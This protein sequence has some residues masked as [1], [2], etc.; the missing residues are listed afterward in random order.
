MSAAHTPESVRLAALRLGQARYAPYF[1]RYALGRRVAGGWAV[2]LSHVLPTGRSL[3]LGELRLDDSGALLEG[4]E[5][6]AIQAELQ[7]AY[8][9][10][11]TFPPEHTARVVGQARAMLGA[12]TAAVERATLW[13]AIEP[14]DEACELLVPFAPHSPE[15]AA[16][17]ASLGAQID[18]LQALQAAV[19]A[20]D[21]AADDPAQRAAVGQIAALDDGGAPLVRR[22]R[23]R[24]LREGAALFLEGEVL[25]SAERPTLEI[26]LQGLVTI[27][28]ADARSDAP[29]ALIQALTR[30]ALEGAVARGVVE[31][32]GAS[33]P[34]VLQ[35][36]D[37]S[38]G[39]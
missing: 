4:P 26:A 7:R 11:A 37:Q 25:E 15:A 9:D 36:L 16:L 32:D 38:A 18:A 39:G 8:Q 21:Q 28:L 14:L 12:A 33:L 34:E 30:A 22:W 29:D 31:I 17:G 13:G 23:A 5:V 6:R 24:L 19:E 20:F 3:A 27:G 35:Q 10:P 2:A 1:L